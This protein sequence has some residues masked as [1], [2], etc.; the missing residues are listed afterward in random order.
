MS[1]APAFEGRWREVIKPAI[2]S[3]EING[4]GLEA[5]RVDART[6]SDSILTEI[7][8]AISRA[9]L[10]FADVTTIDYTTDN[11]R[12]PIRN[13]NVMYEVGIAHA[14][15][16]PEEVLL[17]RSDEDALLFDV[18]NVRV[19]VYKPEE[20]PTAAIKSIQES[21]SN[22]IR[23]IDL[24]KH[25]SVQDVARTLDFDSYWLLVQAS[26]PGGLKPPP[27][28]TMGELLTNT[29]TISSIRRLLELGALRTEFVSIAP[30]LLKSDEVLISEHTNLL[31]YAVTSFGEAVFNYVAT[32]MGLLSPEVRAILETRASQ[33]HNEGGDSP[34]RTKH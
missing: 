17:F 3:V 30:D 16:L 11:S 4:E 25:L 9:L 33:L 20:H 5:Q 28:R 23:E 29:N 2:E 18:S 1:F 21:I 24:R 19:N 6:V 27:T 13:G 8:T 31:G 14:V 7:L 12:T 10:V 34:T 26:M 32:E 22:A 15:R